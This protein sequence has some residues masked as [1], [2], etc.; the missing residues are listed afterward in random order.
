MHWA[1]RN[2]SVLSSVRKMRARQKKRNTTEKKKHNGKNHFKFNDALQCNAVRCEAMCILCINKIG[3]FKCTLAHWMGTLIHYSFNVTNSSSSIWS[4]R[5]SVLMV[6]MLMGCWFSLTDG[7]N[8]KVELA[9]HSI[10]SLF[11]VCRG[12]TNPISTNWRCVQMHQQQQQQ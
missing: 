7:R 8:S 2:E 5:N 3:F 11:F 12:R 10:L 9:I 6:S 1:K 4:N